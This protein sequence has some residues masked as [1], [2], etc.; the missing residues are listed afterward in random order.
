MNKHFI[1]FREVKNWYIGE[2]CKKMPWKLCMQI[3]YPS[4]DT[5]RERHW[6]ITRSHKHKTSGADA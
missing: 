4:H 2:L 6:R 5:K 1:P 3:L